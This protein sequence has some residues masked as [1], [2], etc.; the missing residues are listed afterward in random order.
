MT[1]RFWLRR[2]EKNLRENREA[3]Y[4][5]SPSESIF[6]RRKSFPLNCELIVFELKDKKKLCS[7]TKYIPEMFSE[8]FVYVFVLVGR[9]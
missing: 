7:V 9:V 2:R 3:V 5:T 8:R 6:A 1:S 4:T